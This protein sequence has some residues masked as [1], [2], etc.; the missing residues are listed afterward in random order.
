VA[1]IF[2][3]ANQAKVVVLVCFVQLC[4]LIPLILPHCSAA[5]LP[6]KLGDKAELLSP[7]VF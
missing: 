3:T 4:L 7:L 5:V 2:A 1:N 6:S